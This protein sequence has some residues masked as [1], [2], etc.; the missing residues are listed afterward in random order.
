MEGNLPEWAQTASVVAIALVASIVGVFNY[1]KTQAGKVVEKAVPTAAN[2]AET[3]AVVA[4]SFT[5]SRLMRELID[6]LRLTQEEYAREGLKNRRSNAE[7]KDSVDQMTEAMHT[8][9]D[10]TLNFL[11][12]V[13]GR[14]RER[15][16]KELS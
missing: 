9:V 2:A 13:K 10:T 16:F 1:L 14:D 5:D 15:D 6:A 11:R 8:S 3:A 4:A 7:L 12:F